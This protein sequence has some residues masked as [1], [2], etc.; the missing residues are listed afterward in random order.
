MAMYHRLWVAEETIRLR[1]LKVEDTAENDRPA[2][3]AEETIRLRILKGYRG[4]RLP[5]LRQVAEETIR[6]RILKGL[7]H[8][9]TWR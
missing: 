3:V 9:P 8:S 2:G 1:I 4:R 5:D 7:F 6:L